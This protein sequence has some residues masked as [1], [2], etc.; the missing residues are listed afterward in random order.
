MKKTEIESKVEEMVMPII[1]ENGYSLWDVEYVKEG[2]DYYLRVYVDK[3]GGFTI[4]DC[5]KVSRSLDPLLDEA[6]IID[7]AEI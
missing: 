6:D 7:E 5:E 1:E 2:S 3:E 4:E